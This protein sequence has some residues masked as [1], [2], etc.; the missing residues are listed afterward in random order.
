M[1]DSGL[2]GWDNMDAFVYLDPTPDHRCGCGRGGAT[3]APDVFRVQPWVLGAVRKGGFCVGGV[4][5]TARC[6]QCWRSDHALRCGLDGCC[7]QV[8]IF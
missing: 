5:E 8:R 4:Y 7:K 2:F 1:S 3:S 6:L